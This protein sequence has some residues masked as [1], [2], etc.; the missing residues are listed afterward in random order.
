[1]E[2]EAEG[3]LIGS[4]LAYTCGSIAALLVTMLFVLQFKPHQKVRRLKRLLVKAQYVRSH[5]DLW[6]KV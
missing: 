2:C 1:V 3:V 6:A 5:F 4:T